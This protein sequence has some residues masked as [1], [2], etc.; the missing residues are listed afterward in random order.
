MHVFPIHKQIKQ[1]VLLNWL[2]ILALNASFS[3][4]SAI[5]WKIAANWQKL[6]EHHRISAKISVKRQ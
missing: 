3:C 4:I 6:A 5:W 2:I 1:A